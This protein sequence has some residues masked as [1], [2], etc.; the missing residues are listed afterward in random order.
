MNLEKASILYNVSEVDM[1]QLSL[2]LDQETLRKVELAAKFEHT[3]ISK[4]VVKKLNESFSNSWPENY[5]TL[6]GALE[7]DSFQVES[8]KLPHDSKREEF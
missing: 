2:Y 4:Y 7:D 1:P 3:S 5:E 6:F 8:S